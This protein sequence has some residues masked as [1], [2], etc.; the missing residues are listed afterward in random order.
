MA[1][2]G[3]FDSPLMTGLAIA[4]VALVFIPVLPGLY[5][6]LRPGFSLAVWYALLA[7][8]EW[9]QALLATLTSTSLSTALA[10]LI[11]GGIAMKAFPGR[12]WRALEHRLGLLLSVG[13][14]L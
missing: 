1:S 11:A 14:F 12:S 9:P 8:N 2:R 5:W 7:N 10:L 6:A 3:R 4:A 13:V